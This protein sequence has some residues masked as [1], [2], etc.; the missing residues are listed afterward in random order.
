LLLLLLLLRLL[1]LLLLLLRRWLRLLRLRLLLWLRLLGRGSPGRCAV[2]RARRAKTAPPGGC[3]YA[4]A[5]ADARIAADEAAIRHD[6]VVLGRERGRAQHDALRARRA[7]HG[8]RGAERAGRGGRRRGR[9]GRPARAR[10]RNGRDGPPDETDVGRW[11]RTD[12]VRAS[13]TPR[14]WGQARARW[15]DGCR[16][17]RRERHIVWAAGGARAR[18]GGDTGRK[19]GWR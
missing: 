8:R 7:V 9:C 5:D 2:D 15:R 19:C 18:C 16:W 4:N 1:L 17:T 14:A 3:T 10:P 13:A 12:V 6:L 11:R